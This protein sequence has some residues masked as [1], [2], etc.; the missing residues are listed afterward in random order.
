MPVQINFNSHRRVVWDIEVALKVEIIWRFWR[1]ECWRR[2]AAAPLTCL[3]I[4]MPYSTMWRFCHLFS[5]LTISDDG[6][7]DENFA[8]IQSVQW[9]PMLSQ[10]NLGCRH[11]P[12]PSSAAPTPTLQ[13]NVFLRD[14]NLEFRSGLGMRFT[15]L[16][17]RSR[18]VSRPCHRCRPRC[19]AWL[20][21]THSQELK[22]LFSN[23]VFDWVFEVTT[24]T[25]CMFPARHWTP[26]LKPSARCGRFLL[27]ASLSTWRRM[28]CVFWP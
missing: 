7:W 26:Q 10:F 14:W 15:L 4:Q 17:N 8:T 16:D 9:I 21:D 20:L 22:P 1:V 27:V 11:S 23:G 13:E 24:I 2:S 5:L 18:S 25:G 12:A 19:W 3:Q 28:T 6:D